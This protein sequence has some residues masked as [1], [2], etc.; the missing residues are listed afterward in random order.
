MEAG[1]IITAAHVIE[2]LAGETKITVRAYNHVM[3]EGHEEYEAEVDEIHTTDNEVEKELR[4]RDLAFL[5][6]KD[7]DEWRKRA[8]VV[9]RFGSPERWKDGLPMGTKVVIVGYPIVMFGQDRIRCASTTIQATYPENGIEYHEMAYPALRGMSGGPVF[10]G[11]D[12]AEPMSYVIGVVNDS[13]W[14]EELDG[15]KVT[16]VPGSFSCLDND[17]DGSTCF[18]GLNGVRIDSTCLCATTL[19]RISHQ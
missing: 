10:Y 7:I 12:D 15:R 11:D 14:E 17:R 9:V 13:L 18:S 2:R 19:A 6:I 3:H 16:K 8:T 4:K 5:R 1:L